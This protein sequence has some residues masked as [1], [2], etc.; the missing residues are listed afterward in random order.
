[1]TGSRFDR[2]LVLVVLLLGGCKAGLPAEPPGGDAADPSAPVTKYE[3]APNPY[4][5]SAFEGVEIDAGGHGGHS[6]HGGHGGHQQP[7][8]K[9]AK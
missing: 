1:M 3:A 5:R 2:R 9:G 6:G 7:A 8:P 4:E